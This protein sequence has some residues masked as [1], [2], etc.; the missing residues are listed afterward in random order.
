MVIIR[1]QVGFKAKDVFFYYHN[2]SEYCAPNDELKL[3][4]QY[5]LDFIHFCSS[6]ISFTT[7]DVYH[8]VKECEPISISVISIVILS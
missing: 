5:N 8:C 2:L 3:S 7:N 6:N 4:A 1:I